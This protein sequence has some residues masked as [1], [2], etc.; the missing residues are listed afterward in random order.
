MDF[1]LPTEE[2]ANH[3]QAKKAAEGAAKGAAE[4]KM[5]DKRADKSAGDSKEEDDTT[6]AG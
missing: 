6:H 5:A 4:T 2:E 3:I 1:A